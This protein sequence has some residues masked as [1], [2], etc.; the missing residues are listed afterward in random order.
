MAQLVEFWLRIHEVLGFVPS[1]K[2]VWLYVLITPEAWKLEV[3]LSY[4]VSS[5]V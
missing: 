3:I 5:W 4:I 2:Q 1:T